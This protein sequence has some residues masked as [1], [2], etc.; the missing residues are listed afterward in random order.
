MN[1][2]SVRA[3]LVK[4]NDMTKYVEL[5]VEDLRTRVRFPPVPPIKIVDFQQVKQSKPQG[6][7]SKPPLETYTYLIPDLHL[8]FKALICHKRELV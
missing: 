6:A 1:N 7:V 5:Y 8:K 4:S 2:V 3:S